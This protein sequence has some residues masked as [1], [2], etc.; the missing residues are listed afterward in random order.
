MSAKIENQIEEYWKCSLDRDLDRF[1]Y[2][3]FFRD[4]LAILER[5][6]ALHGRLSLEKYIEH[7]SY[8]YDLRVLADFAYESKHTHQLYD[9]DSIKKLIF[10]PR[11]DNFKETYKND[12]IYNK[13]LELYT[14]LKSCLL[15]NLSAERKLLLME[16]CISAS[17][18]SGKLIGDVDNLRAAF[19]RKISELCYDESFGILTR[20]GL[21]EKVK[22][23]KK[24]FD[25]IFLDF[26]DLHLLNE[27][28]G[29]TE[30]NKRIK[31]LFEKFKGKCIVGRYFSGDEI[32]VISNEC[33]A[34]VKEL[35][36][37]SSIPFKYK[38][39]KQ[40]HGISIEERPLKKEGDLNENTNEL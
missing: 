28:I 10:E 31:G 6:L 11:Y 24:P 27:R 13:L 4:F 1:D 23:I 16:Q 37:E 35:E 9:L 2:F 39:Y 12:H 17:H 40:Q 14:D 7:I 29:Y 15:V 8:Y 34:V 20:N 5:K 21:N 26:T 3:T 19:E 38:I 33:E 25:Y 36:K 18:L 32:L 30:V 22:E